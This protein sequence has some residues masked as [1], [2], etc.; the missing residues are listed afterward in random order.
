MH[1]IRGWDDLRRRIDPVDRRCFAFFHPALVDE[2]LIFVE[3]ALTFG[4]ARRYRAAA[5]R[6]ARPCR[7]GQGA[8]RDILFDLELPAGPV[9]HQ[10]RQFS[11]QAGRS[12]KCRSCR[13]RDLRRAL[14][15]PRLS[16]LGEATDDAG[17]S[18]LRRKARGA[19]GRPARRPIPRARRGAEDPR[20]ARRLLLLKAR[21]PDGRMIDPVARFHL[22]NG[23]RLERIGWMGDLS[24]KGA[25]RILG[26][27]VN[28][29]YDPA[30][31]RATTRPS[32]T[33]TSPPRA[34]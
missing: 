17:L 31:D 26:V 30:E 19:P 14:A 10:L 24:V 7:R 13:D 23:A 1:E 18:S 22:G 8:C 25:V 16:R 2:P 21:R 11:H 15:G 34:Q 29:L 5:R 9:K 33:A 27:M 28:Y 6:E 32:P 4:P 3:V 20:A 12:R